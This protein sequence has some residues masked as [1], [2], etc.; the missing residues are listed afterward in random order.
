MAPPNRN[1]YSKARL[2]PFL[3]EVVMK[4]SYF[5]RFALAAVVGCG[6]PGGR[7]AGS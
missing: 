7:E 1:C 3:Q 2:Q 4:L 5:S 6:V